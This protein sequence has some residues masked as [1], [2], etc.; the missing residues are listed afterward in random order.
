MS[1]WM[2]ILRSVKHYWRTNIALILGVVVGTA[3]IGG[4]LIVGDSVRDSLAAM[5]RKRLGKVE[6]AL[7]GPRFFRE[8]LVDSMQAGSPPSGLS[9]WLQY[10]P[11][12]W[13]N[14]SLNTAADG[15]ESGSMRFT[16]N[17]N[18]IGVD[19]RLWSLLETGG[20]EQPKDGEI[21][22]NSRVGSEL[23]VVA[24]GEI[25]LNV[26]IPSAVPPRNLARRA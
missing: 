10:A 26:E 5:T 21:V 3:V 15:S 23:A 11:A 6:F 24:G 17:V 25:E 8:Q 20:I 7:T 19:E 9:G 16:S 13:L 18:V 12:I 2:L 22:I 14:G 1:F 4:A